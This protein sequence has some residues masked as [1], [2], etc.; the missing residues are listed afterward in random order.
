MR[1]AVLVLPNFNVLATFAFLDPFRAANYL[2]GES[3]YQWRLFSSSGEQERASNGVAISTEDLSALSGWAAD[4]GVVSSS[5]TPEAFYDQETIVGPIRSWGRQGLRV[6]G[7]DTGAYLIAHAGLLAGGRV[8]THYEHID[9]F[10]ELY[11]DI[12]CTE[13]LL[14]VHNK[15][16]TCAGG[17][18]SADLALHILRED[19]GDALANASARYLLHERIREPGERQNLTNRVPIGRTTPDKLRHAIQLMEQNLETP[20]PVPD[21]AKELGLSQRQLSRLF[22]QHTGQTAVQY[23]RNIRL[24]RGRSLIT[25]TEMSILSVSIA[26]GFENTEYFS[27][28]Y[29]VRFGKSPR[30]DRIEGRIPFEYRPWPMHPIPTK[31]HR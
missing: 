17:E 21:L 16:L 11:P 10:R 28:A 4:I 8:A 27:K 30:E 12:E 18:A 15:I 20:I 25:Q 6:C 13:E 19:H 23:Y 26:C 1:I 31:K 24:D 22:T 5:W 9:A 29:R 14:T 3:L 7:L 2:S